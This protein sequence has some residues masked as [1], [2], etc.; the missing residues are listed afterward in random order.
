VELNLRC[1]PDKPRPKR[2]KMYKHGSF[3]YDTNQ[4]T[5]LCES[6]QADTAAH[7]PACLAAAYH[8]ARC[9]PPPTRPQ[10]HGIGP[11]TDHVLNDLL[12]RTL[13]A[14]GTQV[15]SLLKPLSKPL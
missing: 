10:V 1:D 5:V 6:T 9:T 14:Y 2:E 8:L 3:T 15:R 13:K 7:A 12:F 11:D 4:L